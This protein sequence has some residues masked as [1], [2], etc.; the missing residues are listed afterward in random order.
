[1]KYL[2]LSISILWIAAGCGSAAAPETPVAQADVSDKP[3]HEA[4]T[5]SRSQ[6][7]SAGIELGMA[8]QRAIASTLLVNGTVAVLPD[9]K[10]TVS[11]KIA[12][13]IEQFF[14]HEGQQ[15]QKGQA[16]MSVSAAAIFDLQQAYLQAK[17]DLIFLE[18]ELE[19]QKTLSSQQVGAS[20]L[21]EEAQSKYF[22]A[23]GDQ[24]TAA[25]KLQYLGIGLENLEHPERLQ[26]S[27]TVVVRAPIGGN[28]THIPV[29]LGAS[30]QEGTLLCNI[31]GLN[32]LHAH[33]EVFAKDIPLVR[34]GQA[35]SIR[36]PNTNF[37]PLQ[38]K[39]EYISR[40]L[41]PESKTYSLHVHLPVSKNS[42]YLP[43]MP[44]TAEIQTQSAAGSW[45][46]PEAAVLRD[47]NTSHFFVATEGPGD[48]I[49]FQKVVFEPTLRGGGYIGV[50]EGLLDGKKVVLRGANLVDGELRKGEMQE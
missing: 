15:V 4:V 20:K 21:Y 29:N 7:Q 31:V 27:Q 22:R 14:I 1:M 36:F 9:G 30:V 2:L 38:T 45:A 40:D 13:R 26:L 18:K 16:L 28:V 50:P 48:A 49:A 35:V 41:D 25:A 8:E 43:G 23:K 34:E 42:H 33:L 46:L 17:A 44:V 37:T 11:S 12:G 6:L 10:A 39:L 47:G 3:A 32:D 5:L 19:R 24:Q